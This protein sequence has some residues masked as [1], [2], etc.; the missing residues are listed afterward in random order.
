MKVLLA[1]TI[2]IISLT[3]PPLVSVT[4]DYMSVALGDDVVLSCNITGGLT[5]DITY[6]WKHEGIVIEAENNSTLNLS[7]FGLGEAGI[8]SCVVNN[9]DGAGMDSIVIEA[10]GEETFSGI[11]FFPS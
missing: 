4:A 2:F 7:S 6:L 8:Y 9:T 1:T 10:V 3:A 5:T 11:Y